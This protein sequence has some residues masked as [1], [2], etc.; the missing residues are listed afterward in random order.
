MRVFAALPLPE[1]VLAALQDTVSALT[2]RYPR[3]KYT[4][5]AG[6]HVTLHFFGELQEPAVDGLGKVWDVF[7]HPAVA[8]SLGGLGQFPERGAPRV[9][10][11][12]MKKGLEGLRAL[13]ATFQAAIST[14]G[15]AEDP[16]GFSPHVTL[17][18]NNS[19]VMD[20]SWGD[21]IPV[22]GMDFTFHELVLFQSI[23]GPKGAEYVPL[24]RAALAGSGT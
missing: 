14:L 6:M 2:R 20:K 13:N 16:R 7:K 8:A 19:T 24:R 11:I 21:G 1:A 12:G 10:W 15:Y 3:L 18:R 4:G 5:G 22:P 17:A 9:I 23:L